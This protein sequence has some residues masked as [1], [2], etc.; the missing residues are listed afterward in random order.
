M[1]VKLTST[2]RRKG[3][4]GIEYLPP[5]TVLDLAEKSAKALIAAGGADVV[6]AV[7]AEPARHADGGGR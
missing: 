5:G 4:A 3:T 7:E 1:K 6:A 2:F